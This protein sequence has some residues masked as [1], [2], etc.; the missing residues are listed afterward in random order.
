MNFLDKLVIPLSPEHIALLHYIAILILFLFVPF[1]SMVL[2]GTVLS[3]IYKRKGLRESN[4]IYLRFAKD[5]IETVTINTSMGIVLGI[6]T[7]VTAIL[8]FVQ[9]FH[10]AN[11]ITVNFLTGSVFLVTIGLI[12]IYTYRYSF[13]FSELFNSIKEYHSHDESVA[14]ELIKY[15]EKSKRLSA[16]SGKF[17]LLFLLAGI[18]LFISGITIAVFPNEW[19]IKSF[20]SIMF[21]WDVIF[22]LVSFIL[23]AFAFTGSV[24]MFSF[25][26]WNGGRTNIDES[27]KEFVSKRAIMVTAAGTVILPLFLWVNL[28]FLPNDSLSYSVF[29][30]VV[31]AL[32]LLFLG[33]HYL[34]VMYKNS[35]VKYA[36]HIFFVVLFTLMALIIKDQLAIGNATKKQSEILSANFEQVMQ[37]L[38]GENAAPKISGKEIFTN[39]CSACHSFDHKIVGPPYKQTLPK[40]HDDVDK[41]V[42][43]ILNPTQNNPGYPPMPNPGLKPDQA[44][45]VA[46]Y[47]LKE[48]KKYE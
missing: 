31:I 22:R 36:G 32:L 20:L 19:G 12:L 43:F 17:G 6:L 34:Y 35:S 18:W 27:Y 33:Y 1:I 45:A 25:F 37:K 10:T 48:V 9:M 15:R 24:I 7:L 44:R 23:G 30:Y 39:I 21:S 40:Y 11:L 38:T 2:G 41:L 42:T 8:I 47:I 26:Y 46:T 13:S 14:E 5:V 4:H 3:L 28:G 29:T 16:G